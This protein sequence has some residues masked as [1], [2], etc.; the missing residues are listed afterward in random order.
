MVHQ[1]GFVTR[2]QIIYSANV[3][4][5]FT[6]ILKHTDAFISSWYKFK[7]CQGI[8][9]AL[10]FTTIHEQP[11]PLPYC[12]ISDFQGAALAILQHNAA[13]LHGTHQTRVVALFRC[14]PLAQSSL[15]HQEPL[16]QQQG[17]IS[18]KTLIL[19]L[20]RNEIHTLCQCVLRAVTELCK[21]CDMIL[22][23]IWILTHNL[24]L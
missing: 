23:A 1:V 16:T 8:N 14:N 7:N 17:V 21:Y 2:T 13:S 5:F 19:T 11:L 22:F 6:T 15:K 18:Q 4:L 24:C 20:L 10:A 3:S 9:W 12:G